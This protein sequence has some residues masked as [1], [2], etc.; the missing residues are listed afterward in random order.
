MSRYLLLIISI[1][2]I[3]CV[4]IC[5]T[6]IRDMNKLQEGLTGG[7]GG[8]TPSSSTANSA[9]LGGYIY[10]TEATADAACKTKGWKGLCEKADVPP[11]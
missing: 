2:V 10:K 9:Y 5:Y 11:K 6:S 3:G 8:D 7:L 4:Y 1:V